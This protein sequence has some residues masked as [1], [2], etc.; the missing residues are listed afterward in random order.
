MSSSKDAILAKRSV[1]GILRA[2]SGQL[3]TLVPHLQTAKEEAEIVH[4]SMGD[5]VGTLERC[6]SLWELYTRLRNIKSSTASMGEQPPDSR[7][8]LLSDRNERIFSGADQRLWRLWD[9]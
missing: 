5:I 3:E 7:D 8:D 1:T 2:M 6:R 4:K 9:S